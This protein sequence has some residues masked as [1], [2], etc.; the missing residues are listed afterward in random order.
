MKR[1]QRKL[2]GAVAMMLFVIVYALLVVALSHGRIAASP[3]WM[4]LAFYLVAGLAWTLPLL[5]LI[6][7][8]ERGEP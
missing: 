2:L 7:W 8:M 1:R 3:R 4:Q 5:P 6:R